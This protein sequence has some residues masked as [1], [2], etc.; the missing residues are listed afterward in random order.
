MNQFKTQVKFGKVSALQYTDILVWPA[1][2][3]IQV[4]FRYFQ[5]GRYPI[6]TASI[7]WCVTSTFSVIPTV[8][9]KRYT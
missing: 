4:P 1:H 3:F 8:G 2:N 6:N 7:D 5:F 9:A